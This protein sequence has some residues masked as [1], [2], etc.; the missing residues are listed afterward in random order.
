MCG[1]GADSDILHILVRQPRQFMMGRTRNGHS[2]T[3][4]HP[5]ICSGLIVCMAS[6]QLHLPRL[7]V[8]SS[9][10]PDEHPKIGA[11]VTGTLGIP[12]HR[13]ANAAVK[14]P[15]RWEHE[16]GDALPPIRHM[17]LS[18]PNGPGEPAQ[19]ATEGGSYRRCPAA[20]S[21]VRRLLLSTSGTSD[22]TMR[23]PAGQGSSA[24]SVRSPS[25]GE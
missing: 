16:A 7:H 15:S 1:P 25:G 17:S 3:G 20:R 11:Q 4:G 23:A 9:C 2:L 12:P 13:Q 19:S 22:E 8:L 14:F 18:N 21:R 5:A 6:S 24:V 10:G